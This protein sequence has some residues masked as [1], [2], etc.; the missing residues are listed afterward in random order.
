V[1]F[2]LAGPTIDVMGF[3]DALAQQDS[4]QYLVHALD[5]VVTCTANSSSATTISL[6]LP[7][8]QQIA[9][10]IDDNPDVAELFRRFL[11]NE[12]YHIL[13]AADGKAGIALARKAIP[14]VIIL[15]IMLPG[16]D[17][18]DVL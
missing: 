8:R 7:L 2:A 3:Q 4:L 5:A 18:L 9:L 13:S 12:P 10:V 17:G 6:A 14:G 11:A 16:Q 1:N 15:D